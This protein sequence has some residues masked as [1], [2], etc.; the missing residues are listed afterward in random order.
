MGFNPGPMGFNPSRTVAI[1]AAGA[2]ALG[3]AAVLRARAR[4][5]CTA[6]T[7]TGRMNFGAGT[8]TRKLDGDEAGNVPEDVLLHDGRGGVYTLDVDGF[9]LCNALENRGALYDADA[10][11]RDFFPRV[12][13]FVQDLTGAR[14]FAFDHIVRNGDRLAKE[15]VSG[16]KTKFLSQAL[17]NAHGDYTARSGPTRARQLLKPH[18][19]EAEVEDVLGKRFAIVN[20]W[21]PLATVERDPLALCTWPS[22]RPQHVRTNRLTFKHRV[23]ET[24]KVAF[25]ALQKWIYFPK[26]RTDEVL[27]M[28]TFDSDVSS[29][30][31]CLH[32]AAKLEGQDD[33]K[34]AR[35]SIEIR[36]LVLYG[37]D[38]SFAPGFV[39]PHMVPG[40]HDANEFAALL[41]TEALPAADE[42]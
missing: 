10:V 9:Q 4:R 5:K 39:A 38:A 12:E 37:A 33:S 35:Q 31:F 26:M 19:T 22:A 20:V 23:G 30:R 29:A 28:K 15:K 2:G 13:E 34:P 11:A 41:K 18:A 8:H 1:A 32:S 6:D 14:A 3:L 42:W 40:N 36:V 27:V 25:D 24:Y 21:C 17:S 16:E 7:V